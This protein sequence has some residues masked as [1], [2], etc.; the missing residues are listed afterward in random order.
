MIGG[1][2]T[3]ETVHKRGEAPAYLPLCSGWD[4]NLK[5][6]CCSVVG[7]SEMTVGGRAKGVVNVFSNPAVC[8]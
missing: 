6:V 1:E 3:R 2:D 5:H 8:M 7:N 4:E